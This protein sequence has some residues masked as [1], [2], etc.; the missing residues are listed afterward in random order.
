MSNARAA[1]VVACVVES[2]VIDAGKHYCHL[3]S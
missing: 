2:C 3:P 1:W